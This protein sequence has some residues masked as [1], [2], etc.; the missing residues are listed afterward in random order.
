MNKVSK[1][2]KPCLN[3]VG[4]KLF[5]NKILNNMAVYISHNYNLY[6]LSYILKYLDCV[7]ITVFMFKNKIWINCRKSSKMDLFLKKYIIF[8]I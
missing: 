5:F 7:I 6:I 2:N 1:A 4:Y 3:K 8:L